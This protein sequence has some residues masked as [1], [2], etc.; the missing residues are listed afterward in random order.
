[1]DISNHQNGPAP[2]I[3]ASSKSPETPAELFSAFVDPAFGTLVVADSSGAGQDNDAAVAAKQDVDFIRQNGL[4]AFIEENQKR[5][6]EA[7]KEELRAEI[8]GNMGHTEESL[9]QIPADQRDLIE[10]MIAEKIQQRLAAETALNGSM[11]V[12]LA[13]ND[14]VSGAGEG[15]QTDRQNLPE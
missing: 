9:G 14:A 11:Q 7:L 6:L 15:D 1:M 10:K 12:G 13:I 3:S 2:S 5:K 4:L 8:L